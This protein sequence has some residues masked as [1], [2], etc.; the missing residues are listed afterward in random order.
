MLRM[1]TIDPF[2]YT[3]SSAARTSINIRRQTFRPQKRMS[4]LAL[5]DATTLGDDAV[6]VFK[7]PVL[8]SLTRLSRWP[9]LLLSSREVLFPACLL[10]LMDNQINFCHRSDVLAALLQV[11]RS[12]VLLQR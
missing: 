11:I 2:S 3:S 10:T 5:L 12:L 6:I 8:Q 7:R 4:Q 1:I 9:V